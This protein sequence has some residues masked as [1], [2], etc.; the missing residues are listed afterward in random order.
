MQNLDLKY[1]NPELSSS[2]HFKFRIITRNDSESKA[3]W[4]DDHD[5]DGLGLGEWIIVYSAAAHCQATACALPTSVAPASLA[6]LSLVLRPLH[7]C[8]S[9][10]S[11]QSP[12]P[13]EAL[14]RKYPVFQDLRIFAED[15]PYAVFVGPGVCRTHSEG[16]HFVVARGTGRG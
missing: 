5:H 11:P 3:H 12:E 1:L 6:L 16:G 9:R 4:G 15:L 14:S 7:S 13:L 8:C 2:V 10:S